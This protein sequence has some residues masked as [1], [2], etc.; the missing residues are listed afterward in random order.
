MAD[1]KPVPNPNPDASREDSADPDALP[2]LD[3]LDPLKRDED[4][5]LPGLDPVTPPIPPG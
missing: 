3:P 2:V 5:D 4:D 1:H